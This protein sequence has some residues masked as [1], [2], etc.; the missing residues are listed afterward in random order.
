MGKF[1]V[2]ST[3]FPSQ[4]N[5]SWNLPLDKCVSDCQEESTPPISIFCE[6]NNV[7]VGWLKLS[8]SLLKLL[9]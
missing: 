9:S 1:M 6:G 4:I 8:H 5:R 3:R 2:S 7:S